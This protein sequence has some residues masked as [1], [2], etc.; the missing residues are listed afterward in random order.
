MQSSTLTGTLMF[1]GSGYIKPGQ[2]Y[3]PRPLP[4]V[5][6]DG[7]ETDLHPILLAVFKNMHG[8]YATQERGPDFYRVTRNLASAPV[9]DYN[10]GFPILRTETGFS[11]VTSY[12][13]MVLVWLT[14]RKV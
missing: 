11:N 5:Q 6:K 8:K 13:K 3:Q 9:F 4:L 12:L 10:D 7:S 2:D 1:T 14:G